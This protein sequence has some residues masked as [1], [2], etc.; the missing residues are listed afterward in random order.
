MAK[1]PEVKPGDWITIGKGYYSKSA[2]VS[3]VYENSLFDDI[4]VVYLDD[5]DRAINE[6]VVWKEDHW[7]FKYQEPIGVYADNSD[8]LRKFVRILRRGS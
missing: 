3:L 8:R 5:R 2:V 1:K 7:E 4:E 6:A